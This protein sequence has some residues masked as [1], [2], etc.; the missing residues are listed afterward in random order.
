LFKLKY[1]LGPK[2]LHGLVVIL[3]PASWLVTV[4]SCIMHESKVNLSAQF[5]SCCTIIVPD[6]GI[7]LNSY[8]WR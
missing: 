2:P 1:E 5:N 6:R 3:S 7:P 8:K 4:L